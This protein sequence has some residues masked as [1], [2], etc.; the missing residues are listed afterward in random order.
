MLR[1]TEFEAVYGAF[2][3]QVKSEIPADALRDVS[4]GTFRISADYLKRMRKNR[5]CE[6][7]F[8]PYTLKE[9]VYS[10]DEVAAGRM[11]A[12]ARSCLDGYLPERKIFSS[13]MTHTEG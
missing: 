3:E 1:V 9:G 5:P 12:F 2:F 10:Y 11:L 8:Y 6:I 4:I 7:T 13:D